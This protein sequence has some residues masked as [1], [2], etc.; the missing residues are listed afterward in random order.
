M[1]RSDV[2]GEDMESGNRD[3]DARP[4]DHAVHLKLRLLE[5]RLVVRGDEVPA[6]H[7]LL[8]VVVLAVDLGGSRLDQRLDEL[9]VGRLIPGQ[10]AVDLD[11]ITALG[12]PV[13]GALAGT[14]PIMGAVVLVDLSLE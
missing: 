6:D 11:V 13:L 10:L 2:K 7:A 4:A 1:G 12:L 14:V 9:G 3:L 8:V 5:P